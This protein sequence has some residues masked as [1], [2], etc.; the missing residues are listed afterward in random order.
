VKTKPYPG[1]D[2]AEVYAPARTYYHRIKASTKRQPNVRSVYFGKQKVFLELFWIHLNQK[3]RKERNKRIK[4]FVCGI[5]LLRMTRSEPTVKQNPNKS[6]ELLYRFAGIT[7]DK[8][9][10][11]IQV[12]ENKRTKRKDLLSVF[13]AN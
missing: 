1:S 9:L 4:F 12:K 7:P 11:Y 5:E 2:Y 10:F 13:P 3:N 6:N 8:E